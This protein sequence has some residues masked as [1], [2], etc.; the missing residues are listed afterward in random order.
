[1]KKVSLILLSV[2]FLASCSKTP[3]QK[4]EKVVLDYLKTS[5][6]EAKDCRFEKLETIELS[7]AKEYKEAL[8]SLNYYRE[9]KLKGGDQFK[10]S[11]MQQGLIRMKQRI[12]DLKEFYKTRKYE[13]HYS[14]KDK[15]TDIEVHDAVFLNDRLNK[16]VE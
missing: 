6:V 4:A 7:S 14:Y 11:A 9:E 12:K 16:V 8:D 13:I 15:E 3:Q 5:K 1:M 10:M 2:L